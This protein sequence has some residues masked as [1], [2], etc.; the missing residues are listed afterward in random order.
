[1]LED[2]DRFVDDQTEIYQKLNKYFVLTE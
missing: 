2:E 1:M